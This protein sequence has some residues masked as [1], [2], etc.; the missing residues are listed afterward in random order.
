M[1]PAQFIQSWTIDGAALSPLSYESLV[2]LNLQPATAEFLTQAGLPED[3]A[4]F[5]SFVQSNAQRY[6]T[7]NK[8]SAH[9]DFLE[10]E[11]DQYVYIGS[12][13]DG[14]VIAIHTAGNDK[15]VW[16]DH[17][18]NFTP[19]FFNSSIGSLAGCLVAYRDFIQAM[20]KDNGEDAYLNANF[21]DMHM[22][23]LKQ[24]MIGADPPV[25][26]IDGFWK[27]TLEMDLAMRE[28]NRK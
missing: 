2:N 3:A 17:E 7:I 13:G 24:Q 26:T 23:T 8:L 16:L 20:Q 11:F 6:N 4:P 5:L 18:D 28:E 22:D 1:T 19:R 14:D 12:C 21:S 27:D 9:F 10:P 25:L 15:V